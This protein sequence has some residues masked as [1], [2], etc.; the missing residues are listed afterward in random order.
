M[1]YSECLL[2]FLEELALGEDG[3]TPVSMST[4]QRMRPSIEVNWLTGNSKILP[5]DAEK[6]IG[7]T[8]HIQIM[9]F[10]KYAPHFK[11]NVVYVSKYQMK[12][13]YVLI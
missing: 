8:V 1:D 2:R 11:I 12:Y 4:K 7:N 9:H 3:A 10:L 5:T 6:S 13:I